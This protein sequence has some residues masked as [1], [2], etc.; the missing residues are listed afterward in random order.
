MDGAFPVSTFRLY[1]VTFHNFLENYVFINTSYICASV[2]LDEDNISVQ[3]LGL[4][5]FQD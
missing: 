1:L 5:S 3:G 2:I 4:F